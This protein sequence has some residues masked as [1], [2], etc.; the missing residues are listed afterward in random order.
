MEVTI[1]CSLPSAGCSS[2]KGTSVTSSPPRVPQ[3]S[4]TRT[5]YETTIPMASAG[6]LPSGTKVEL[7]KLTSSSF[8]CPSSA[9]P[10]INVK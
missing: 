9:T 10:A 5:E 2:L 1:G 4:L 6:H 8:R 7:A 3:F